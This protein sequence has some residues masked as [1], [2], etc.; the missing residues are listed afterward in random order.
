MKKTLF[1]LL[2]I[3][4]ILEGHGH[5]HDHDHDEEFNWTPEKSEYAS[6]EIEEA[7]PGKIQYFTRVSGRILAHPDRLAYVI[8]KAEGV[9][10]KVQKNVGDCVE[11]GEVLA[12]IESRKVAEAKTDFLVA[13]NKVQAKQQILKHEAALKGISPER[14]YLEAKLNAEEAE[15]QMECAIQDLYALG[16]SKDEIEQMNFENPLKRRLYPIKAPFDGKVIERNVT[17]GELTGDSKPAFL[18][19]NFDQV[20]VELHVPQDDVGYLKEGLP[21]DII[22]VGGKQ[23]SVSLSKINPSICEQTRQATAIAVLD[24]SSGKW[25]PGQYVQGSILTKTIE[26]PV[27]IPR[28]AVQKMKGESYVFI[29]YEDFFEPC[30][31]KMGKMDAQ[32]VQIISGLKPGDH[33]VSKNAFCLKADYE[34]EEVEHEH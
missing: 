12:V 8:P 30:K 10:F 1:G 31:V 21:L 2:L 15:L 22:S 27:V 34:K 20:W 25:I 3:P 18:V 29:Q 6:I 5:H 11:A 16:F 9:V 19:G 13:L 4:L 32:R 33:Y 14:D 24:N 23:A 26:L 28:E 7:G 17:L